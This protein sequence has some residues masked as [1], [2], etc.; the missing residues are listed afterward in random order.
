[1]RAAGGACIQVEA[2]NQ[3][4]GEKTETRI[5]ITLEQIDRMIQVYEASQR[6]S[7]N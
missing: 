3:E 1:M 6:A 4:T 7:R 2:V 5:D